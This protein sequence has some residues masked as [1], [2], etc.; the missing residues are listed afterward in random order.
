MNLVDFLNYLVTP[1]GGAVIVLVLMKEIGALAIL[2]PGLKRLVGIGLCLLV[3][4]LATGGLFLLHAITVIDAN[5]LFQ[6][7]MEAFLIA[8]SLQLITA[9]T[10]IPALPTAIVDGTRGPL[11]II[12]KV[13]PIKTT[14]FGWW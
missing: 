4:S 8:Q 1:A 6:V 14:G 11:T 9:P 7:F 10:T 5:V 2:E 3:S 12:L 13:I